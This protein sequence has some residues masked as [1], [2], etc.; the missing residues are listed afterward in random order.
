MKQKDFLFSYLSYFC[1]CCRTIA[2]RYFGVKQHIHAWTK[3]NCFIDEKKTSEKP[4]SDIYIPLTKRMEA[5][6][7]H[8][9]K[10]E[11]ARIVSTKNTNG[12]TRINMQ[13]LL[14]WLENLHQSFVYGAGY[15]GWNLY[16]KL[17]TEFMIYFFV[18]WKN[19]THWL[20]ISVKNYFP[21]GRIYWRIHMYSHDVTLK[22]NIQ[23]VR[24][25]KKMQKFF[26]RMSVNWIMCHCSYSELLSLGGKCHHI[27]CG[28]ILKI[29]LYCCFNETQEMEREWMRAKKNEKEREKERNIE[30]NETN[31]RERER[32]SERE[33]E[34]QKKN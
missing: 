24:V 8:E 17:L 9:N 25:K 12:E 16:V 26:S 5:T 15:H 11:C 3:A 32:A 19:K 33:K 4:L 21:L 31:E 22:Q 6:G 20:R 34:K 7:T 2:S 29:T 1:S 30:K 18:R 27:E 28:F 10:K 23:L 13:S 14:F